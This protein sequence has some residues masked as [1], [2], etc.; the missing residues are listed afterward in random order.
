MY[1]F[2]YI[3]ESKMARDQDVK[4]CCTIGES[5]DSIK[6]FETQGR[7][8]QKSK[9][10]ISLAQQKRLKNKEECIPVPL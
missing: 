10:G 6:Y 7:Y 4:R 1:M 2:K 3:H 5:A 8:H 9:T